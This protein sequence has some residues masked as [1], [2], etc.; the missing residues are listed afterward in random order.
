MR[1]HSDGS[2]A[3][4]DVRQQNQIN[5]HSKFHL[6]KRNLLNVAMFGLLAAAVPA[7]TFVSCKD[8]DEDFSQIKATMK[9][10]KQALMDADAAIQKQVTALE[11][12][13]AT[14]NETLDNLKKQQGTNTEGIKKNAEAIKA[15]AEDIAKLKT[16]IDTYKKTQDEIRTAVEKLQNDKLDASEL[17]KINA[18]IKAA[19][20]AAAAANGAAA[21]A[22]AAAD[23]ANGAAGKAQAAADAAKAAA[24]AALVEAQKGVKAAAEAAKA[25]EVADGK[26][27]KAQKDLET[28]KIEVTKS[29]ES[30]TDMLN[31]YKAE[32]AKLV[33]KDGELPTAIK[34]EKERVDE[35]TTQLAEVK[36]T[37]DAAQTAEQVAD[38]VNVAV[39]KIKTLEKQVKA[40]LNVM[41][42]VGKLKS[43][44]LE[45]EFSYNGLEAIETA[46]Y[47]LTKLAPANPADANKVNYGRAH[48]DNALSFPTQTPLGEYVPAT[49]A[50]YNLNPSTA[51]VVANKD[52][53]KFLGLN[54]VMQVRGT[55]GFEA[56]A[57]KSVTVA[58]GQARVELDLA[59]RSTIQTGTAAGGSGSIVT[60]EHVS[61]IALR[62]MV[63]DTA[64]TSSY[65]ALVANS[66]D[67][68][69]LYQLGSDNLAFDF[70][71]R[72]LAHTLYTSYKEPLELGKVIATRR[73]DGAEQ[74]FWDENA[75]QV[76][77][78][79]VAAGFKYQFDLVKEDASDENY[80]YFTL[81]RNTGVLTPTD[82][83]GNEDKQAAVDRV[84]HVR[85][86]LV[87]G[88]D[89]VAVGYFDVKVTGEVIERVVNNIDNPYTLSCNDDAMVLDHA[90]RFFGGVIDEVARATGYT[91][92]QVLTGDVKTKFAFEMH[93]ATLATFTKTPAGAW[94]KDATPKFEIYVKGN[95]TATTFSVSVKQ[96][97]ADDMKATGD[98]VSTY[99]KMSNPQGITAYFKIVWRPSVVHNAPAVD[100]AADHKPIDNDYIQ[101]DGRREFRVNTGQ[102]KKYDFSYDLTRGFVGNNVAI[103][104]KAPSPYATALAGNVK[105][106]R[107][108][109]VEPTT[110]YVMG[111]SGA[112]YVVEVG[113]DD[114]TLN[115]TKVN[116]QN[117]KVGGEQEIVKLEG[118]KI[119]FVALEY[120]QDI[121]NKYSRDEMEDGQTFTAYIERVADYCKDDQAIDV[122]NNQFA[123]RFIR[124]INIAAATVE[125]IDDAKQPVQEI[126]AVINFTDWRNVNFDADP[127]LY[128]DSDGDGYHIKSIV[129]EPKDK[130]TTNL[131]GGTLGVTSLTSKTSLLKLEWVAPTNT[132]TDPIS[133]TNSGKVKYTASNAV[134]KEFKVRIPLVV[135]YRWGKIRTHIDVTIKSTVK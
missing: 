110:R 111:G 57:V 12:K 70:S 69:A 11:G 124:P 4:A 63:G 5:N 115:A 16:A 28:Y 15:C 68:L 103:S 76:D 71:G 119:K 131:D 94:T 90:D 13:I 44:E 56:P 113:A 96:A 61:T 55:N 77:N 32:L 35:L 24:D 26:A 74:L 43:M 135:T 133:K 3:I 40:N 86:S 2:I 92:V 100:Y 118:D 17:V 72:A 9:S 31:K 42:I 54:Q 21:K 93:G 18:G 127:K 78:P 97:V 125:V 30:Q 36:K 41:E 112:R 23:A 105:N 52:N 20:D 116:A 27:T 49:Y 22:Q 130:W 79:V 8:Y 47:R 129:A 64:V 95:I 88:T 123:V 108:V 73:F 37:A 122:T 14:V 121:L 62:Y 60:R 120:A 101:E 102:V 10:D 132:I 39:E 128:G 82:I 58:N 67:Q 75:A 19:A 109:F 48:V 46:S 117:A 1:L 66:Y 107:F 104:F 53:F 33:G 126:P 106:D 87:K 98:D 85:V 84:A 7:S 134:T 59:K 38:A 25:A 34:T 50:I 81:D 80:K 45:T 51:K 89:V 99:V 65:A 114:V 83:N 91:K 29:F 6:M